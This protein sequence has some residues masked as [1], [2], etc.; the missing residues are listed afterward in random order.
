M[1]GPINTASREISRYFVVTVIVLAGLVHLENGARSLFSHPSPSPSLAAAATVG[2][3]LTQ[4]RPQSKPGLPLIAACTCICTCA[5]G[6]DCCLASVRLPSCLAPC[7]Q[8]ASNP[9]HPLWLVIALSAATAGESA[10]GPSWPNFGRTSAPGY[11]HVL[12][13]MVAA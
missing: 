3:V 6:R 1:R 10:S 2:V 12:P 13:T 8:D 11:L 7:M 9:A 4:A 5:L